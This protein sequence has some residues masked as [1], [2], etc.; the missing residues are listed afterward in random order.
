MAQ[1][2]QQGGEL[3]LVRHG[4]TEWSVSGRHTGLTDLPLTEDGRREAERIRPVLAGR[5]FARV[6]S[7]PLQRALRTCEL[8][9]FAG[10]VEVEHDLVE[11]NYGDYEGL[12]REEIARKAGA[13]W[14]VFTHGCAGG[15][16][17]EQIAARIDRLIAKV[18]GIEGRVLAFA[19][20]HVLRVLA[21]RWIGAPVALGQHLLLDTA[22][23]SVLGYYRGTPVLKHW[24]AP[25][26]LGAHSGS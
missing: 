2:A 10:R 4:Q 15:E 25:F 7:S 6:L 12:K 9:G 16:S 26:D 20:G 5:E 14:G 23:L 11:W 1:H 17:P 24:N 18:R 3:F 22:T 13:D 8:A 21:A 19:H